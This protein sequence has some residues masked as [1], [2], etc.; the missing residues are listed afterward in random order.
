MAMEV[1]ALTKGGDRKG[2]KGGK[3]AEGRVCW[4]CG[5]PGHVAKDCPSGKGNGGTPSPKAGGKGA[6]KGLSAIGVGNPDT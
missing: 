4:K 3:G 6:G 5:K 2:P 1:D